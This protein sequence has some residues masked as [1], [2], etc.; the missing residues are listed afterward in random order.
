MRKTVLAVLL[1]THALGVQAKAPFT[2]RDYS[3]IYTCTGS[4][5]L[6]GDYEVK[7][8]LKLNLDSSHGRFAAYEYITETSNGTK[9]VGQAIADRNLLAISFQ[10]NDK[11]ANDQRQSIGH[12]VMADDKR[13]RWSFHKRYYE[14]DGNGGNYGQEYCVYNGPILTPDSASSR[15]PAKTTK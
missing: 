1:L 7:V 9:Y 14:P 11:N 6:V 13:G 8:T 5:E 10:F 12:A 2:G 3:G 15:R 4:N